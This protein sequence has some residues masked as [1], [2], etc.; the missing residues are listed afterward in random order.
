[1]A[2]D[3]DIFAI[4]AGS[5][6]NKSRPGPKVVAGHGGLT[7]LGAQAV[8]NAAGTISLNLVDMGT[9]GTSVAGT[10]ATQGSTVFAQNVPQAFTVTTPVVSEGHYIGVEEKNVGTADAMTMVYVEYTDGK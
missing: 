7:I 4:N 1:M 3:I 6:N 8:M 2:N 5:L 10:I 9:A